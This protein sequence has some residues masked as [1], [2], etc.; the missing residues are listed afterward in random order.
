MLKAAGRFGAVT[1]WGRCLYASSQR[2]AGPLATFVIL[3]AFAIAAS[4]ASAQA[5]R[6]NDRDVKAVFLFNFAQFVDWP[7]AAFTDER[8]PLVIGVLGEDPFGTTLDEVV[9]GEVVKNRSLVVQ[10]F[11][12]VEDITTCHILFISPSEVTRQAQMVAALRGRAILTVGETE[13][14]ST[15]AGG[16]I[17]FLTEQNRIRLRVNLGAVRAAGL[18]IS[19]KMLRPADIVGDEKRP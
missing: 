5:S 15:A 19:S 16:M 6:F 11:R 10:R 17:R 3:A 1:H 9:K 4:S 8:A 13:G 12:R 14:F 18:T 2:R 7:A